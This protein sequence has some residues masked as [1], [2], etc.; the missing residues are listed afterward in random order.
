M[1]LSPL[2]ITCIC[3]GVTLL[4]GVLAQLGF[5]RLRVRPEQRRRVIKAW[6]YGLVCLLLI[7][8]V[9]IWA[10]QLRSAAL[11]IS[12]FA[13]A[14]VLAGKELI[15]C[16]LGWWI[17]IIGGHFR[18][19]DRI[20]VGAYKGDVLDYGMLT[21]TLLEVDPKRGKQQRTGSVLT[22]PNSLLLSETVRNETSRLTYSW[23]EIRV[24]VPAGDDWRKAEAEL[25]K[26]AHDEWQR[27]AELA[28]AEIESLAGDFSTAA[29]SSE[30]NIF[31]TQLDDGRVSLHLDIGLP[32]RDSRAVEDRIVRAYLNRLDTLG[33]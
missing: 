11:V 28:Q 6:R 13:V 25:S 14:I 5:R 17:K 33:S 21:T 16:V 15:Q 23:H 7:L 4:V 1:S 31:V 2:V 19:G 12:A 30:P 8:L 22:F 26:C 32:V 29:G 24:V 27:H 18:M 20:Q 3:I 10:Q 9:A